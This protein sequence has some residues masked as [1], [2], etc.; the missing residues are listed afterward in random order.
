MAHPTA[1]RCVAA[2]FSLKH[3]FSQFKHLMCFLLLRCEQSMALMRFANH[4][5]LLLFIFHYIFFF[6]NGVVIPSPH[7]AKLPL[8]L[9]LTLY[10]HLLIKS[11]KGVISLRRHWGWRVCVSLCKN[12]LINKAPNLEWLTFP[13][14]SLYLDYPGFSHDSFLLISFFPWHLQKQLPNLSVLRKT[15]VRVRCNKSAS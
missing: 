15:D 9:F 7:T 12:L 6:G 1:V 13:Q 2:F 11:D 8:S 4:C 5:I 14:P 3:L 10:V